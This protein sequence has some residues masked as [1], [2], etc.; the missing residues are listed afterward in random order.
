MLYSQINSSEECQPNVV[1]F[2]QR[3][4]AVHSKLEVCIPEL[5]FETRWDGT[6]GHF[7]NCRDRDGT[8]FLPHFLPQ[9]LAKQEKRRV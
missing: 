3:L 2:D 8:T 4:G 5:F 9:N 1:Y 7:P 6:G